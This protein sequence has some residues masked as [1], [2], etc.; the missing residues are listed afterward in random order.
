MYRIYT[1]QRQ[2]IISPTTT[3]TGS[4]SSH[5]GTELHPQLAVIQFHPQLAM[6]QQ[7]FTHNYQWQNRISPTTTN[8]RTGFY[9]HGVAG[10][11]KVLPWSS[12]AYGLVGVVSSTP[13]NPQRCRHVQGGLVMNGAE[14]KEGV[15]NRG[16]TRR[17]RAAKFHTVFLL[18]VASCHQAAAQKQSTRVFEEGIL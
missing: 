10:E 2:D 15:V 5:D 7:D 11:A 18:F 8:D 16:A 4:T 6:T 12:R 17:Y 3:D 1:Q 14:M 13:G 9:S